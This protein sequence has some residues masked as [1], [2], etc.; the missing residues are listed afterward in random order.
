MG[1]DKIGIDRQGA[2]CRLDHIL[3][4][5]GAMRA[6]ATAQALR[7]EIAR[8]G[9]CPDRDGLECPFEIAGHVAVVRVFDEESFR[10][11]RSVPQF[12]GAGRA[13]NRQLPL[14]GPAVARTQ[15]GMGQ[16]K[17][18]IELDRALEQRNP[19]VASTESRRRSWRCTPST[20]RVDAVVASSKRLFVCL[21]RRQGLSDA[22]PK[23]TVP[24]R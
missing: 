16:S 20:P 3:V 4:P 13:L 17:L 10:V 15:T 23:R 1:K 24:S 5:A 7:V 11:G 19:G 8:I 14:A 6:V 18:G 12:V 21:D 22:R 9:L 2:L